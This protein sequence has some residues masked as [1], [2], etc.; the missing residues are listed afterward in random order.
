M[1]ETPASPSSVLDAVCHN[2][3]RLVSASQQPLR[4]LRVQSGDA[5]VEVEWPESQGRAAE[6]DPGSADGPPPGVD[7]Q[8]ASELHYIRA[9][10][11]GTFYHAPEPGARP[12]VNVGDVVEPGQP[13][14]IVE[15]MK[16]MNTIEADAAGRVVEILV[17]NA[18]PVE[19]E[20]RLI[21]LAP[22]TT[23]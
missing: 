5:I 13:V 7:G 12:F 10:M 11:V 22:V 6:P 3:V 21:A 17:P 19:F 18:E 15:V 16:L 8:P 9:P 1:N 2:V 14:G 23:S 4:R 20:Q